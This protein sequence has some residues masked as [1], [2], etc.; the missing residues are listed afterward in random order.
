MEQLVRW[1][2]AKQAII[3]AKS[4]DE[5][6]LIRDQAEAFRY[7]AKQAKES[8][9]AVN[10]IAEI[11]IRAE[12]RAGTFLG[13][14]GPKHGGDRKSESRSTDLTLKKLDVTKNESSDWQRIA[15]IPSENF[16][17]HIEKIKEEKRELTT[18]GVLRLGQQIKSDNTKKTIIELPKDGKYNVIVVDPPWPIGSFV[19]DKWHSPI[20]EKYNTMDIEEIKNVNVVSLAN[21]ICSLFLW[22]THSFLKDALDIIDMWGFKYFCCITWDKGGGWSSN[23]FHKRTELCLYA[24]RGG[25]NINQTGKYIP[26]IIYEKKTRH[27]AKP[28][29]FDELILTNTP[30]PRIELFAR[31]KKE[32]FTVWGN[33]INE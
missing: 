7:A 11:R 32:G 9:E 5:L 15:E 18:A 20:N 4:V 22:T 1:E 21:D 17:S 12:R 28:I 27:S 10:N 33:E 31:E 2:K 29:I 6:L 3:E 25:I 13:V 24:Y 14:D 30:E 19:L 8:I 26:T 16:E 23:G